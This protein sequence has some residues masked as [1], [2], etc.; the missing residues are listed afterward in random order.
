MKT[1]VLLA[2]LSAE[3]VF[4]DSS[5]EV[6]KAN[7]HLLRM[8]PDA[9]NIQRRTLPVTAADAESVLTRSK[10]RWIGDSVDVLVPVVNNTPLGYAIIDNVMGKDQPITYLVVVTPE[11]V[12]KGVEVLA[13][14]ESYGGE[15]R[16]SSWLNQF[17]NKQHT[18]PLR[19]G[20]DIRNITGATISARSITLGVKKVLCILH[21]LK[22][23]L[24]H[25]P[26][27][28]H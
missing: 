24:E 22:G 12:V 14:R 9:V 13:Y 2:A 4:G 26:W 18:D 10:Q 17:M 1:L 19:P 6:D 11:L 27:E 23:R 28:S 16:N 15:I 5:R 20:G 8:F 7:E 3:W 25:I 21:T